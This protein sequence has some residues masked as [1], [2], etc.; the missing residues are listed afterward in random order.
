MADRLRTPLPKSCNSSPIKTATSIVSA[1]ST[2]CSDDSP[3]LPSDASDLS[4][5][6]TMDKQLRIQLR[7]GVTP[8]DRVD[9]PLMSENEGTCSTRQQGAPS[10]ASSNSGCLWEMHPLRETLPH[11]Y[12][13]LIRARGINLSELTEHEIGDFD[14]YVPWLY[15]KRL[16]I[17]SW[18]LILP[19]AI[20]LFLAV[21][22]SLCGLFVFFT[23]INHWRRP[24]CGWRRLIDMVGVMVSI[25]VHS[26]KAFAHMSIDPIVTKV[27]FSLLVIAILSYAIGRTFG[28]AGNFYVSTRCHQTLHT[29]ACVGNCLLYC[30]LSCA[31]GRTYP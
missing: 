14:V 26:V 15:A 10:R 25:I 5:C 17:T 19:A 27:W 9:F 22:I 16:W 20:G 7:H 6:W 4:E 8:Y 23:S 31:K 2:D 3:D 28:E 29:L 11:D 21:P 13:K 1:G 18:F 30:S 12:I 24:R